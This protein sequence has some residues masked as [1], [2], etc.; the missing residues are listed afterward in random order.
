M[1]GQVRVVVRGAAGRE[2]ADMK[3]ES[4]L[5]Y[6]DEVVGTGAQPQ[7]GNTVVEHDSGF[8][9]DGPK[10]DS[11]HDHGG[12]LEFQLSVGKV[13]RGWVEGVSTM[14]VGGKRKRVTPPELTYGSRGWCDPTLCAPYV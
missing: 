12:Q 1:T 8:L 14:Q 9:D 10:F 3:T 13:T 4:G 11:S 5:E 2:C 6:T 7:R